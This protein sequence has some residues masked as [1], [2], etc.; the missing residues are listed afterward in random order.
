MLVQTKEV[1]MKPDDVARIFQSEEYKAA[2][3]SGLCTL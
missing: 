1:S 2:A 3:D